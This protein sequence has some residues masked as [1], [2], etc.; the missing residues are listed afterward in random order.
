MF[1]ISRSTYLLLVDIGNTNF[2]EK[3]IRYIFVKKITIKLAKIILE[4][5]DIILKHLDT[6]KIYINI[7]IKISLTKCMLI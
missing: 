5:Y 3:Y 6:V 1:Q 2:K 7:F 4:Q